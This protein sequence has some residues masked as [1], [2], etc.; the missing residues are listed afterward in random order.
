MNRGRAIDMRRT[1]RASLKAGGKLIDLKYL[2]R[3]TQVRFRSVP[4]A[5]QVAI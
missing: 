5:L 2:G 4:D 1:L 3:R